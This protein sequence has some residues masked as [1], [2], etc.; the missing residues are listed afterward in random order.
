MDAEFQKN[1]NELAGILKLINK[2]QKILKSNNENLAK[3]VPRW[4]QLEYKLNQLSQIYIYLKP[5]LASSR[6][7]KI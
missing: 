3:V 2:A 7:L 6:V 4:L 5:V 1:L